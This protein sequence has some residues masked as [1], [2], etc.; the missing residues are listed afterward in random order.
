MNVSLTAKQLE[1]TETTEHYSTV[2]VSGLNGG[3]AGGVSLCGARSERIAFLCDYLLTEVESPEALCLETYVALRRLVF[4]IDC[5]L[6]SSLR[7]EAKL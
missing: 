5:R 4:G 2:L 7:P 6:E 3:L 1:P